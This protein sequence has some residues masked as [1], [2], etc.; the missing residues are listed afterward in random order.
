[1]HIRRNVIEY[2]LFDVNGFR[3]VFILIFFSSV[4]LLFVNFLLDFMAIAAVGTVSFKRMLNIPY[5]C[6]GHRVT[7]VQCQ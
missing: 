7:F 3:W 1:M 6:L 2:A 4:D 5:R